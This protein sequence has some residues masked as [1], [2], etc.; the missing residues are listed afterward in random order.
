[1]DKKKAFICTALYTVVLVVAL[2]ASFYIKNDD[3]G[4]SLYQLIMNMVANAWLGC[5]VGKFYR[6]IMN[7]T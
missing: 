2:T 1:M 5:S 6:W 4:I 3:Y 7:N